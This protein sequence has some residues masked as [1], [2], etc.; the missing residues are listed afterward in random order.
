MDK[1][2]NV[3]EIIAYTHVIHTHVHNHTLQ[4]IISILP[5]LSVDCQEWLV[6]EVWLP[7]EQ[8]WCMLQICKLPATLSG[9][10]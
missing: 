6:I 5:G 1:Y 7:F 2:A 8:I 3:Y 9:R 4:N 10:K